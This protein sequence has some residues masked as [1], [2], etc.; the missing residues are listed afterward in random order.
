MKKIF[1]ILASVA[2]SVAAALSFS[3]CISDD[4]PDRGGVDDPP[5]ELAKV[6]THKQFAAD[7]L[8]EVMNKADRN[9]NVVVSPFC[10][11]HAF[12]MLA[13]GAEGNTLNEILGTLLGTDITLDDANPMLSRHLQS[14]K[15][16]QFTKINFVNSLW[17]DSSFPVYES[18]TDS[19]GYYYSAEIKKVDDITTDAAREDIN[20]WVES[21]TGGTIKSLLDKNISGKGAA[22]VNALQ[23][24]GKWIIPFERE[25]TKDGVFTTSTGDKVPSRMMNNILEAPYAKGDGFSIVTLP[26]WD[27]LCVEIVLPDEGETPLSILSRYGSSKHTSEVYDV[28]LSMPKFTV[29]YDCGSLVKELK[30]L[31]IVDAFDMSRSNFSKLSPQPFAVSEIVQKSR[32]SV[33]EDGVTAFSGSS[34]SGATDSGVDKHVEFTV[35]RP[36]LFF[37]RRNGGFCLF[38]GVVNTL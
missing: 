8:G 16:T 3:A 11:S 10:L 1:N 15:D 5:R 21:S 6:R 30:S 17:V 18:F 7:F 26:L 2:L 34:V 24:E 35:D 25:F 20:R 36:F 13:N 23:L 33:D 12:Y 28:I 37:I 9:E 19:V 22:L 14:L 4:G 31:G 27:Y 38:A 29:E 32:I